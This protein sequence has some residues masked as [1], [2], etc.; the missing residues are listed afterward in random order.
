MSKFWSL[1]YKWIWN[2]VIQEW[3]LWFLDHDTNKERQ[4]FNSLMCLTSMIRRECSNI[5]GPPQV[6]GYSSGLCN[7][8]QY[9]HTASWKI[10]NTLLTCKLLIMFYSPSVFCSMPQL[11]SDRPHPWLACS[12]IRSGADQP[13][14]I[15]PAVWIISHYIWFKALLWWCCWGE[16]EAADSVGGKTTL[17]LWLSTPFCEF[18]DQIIPGIC[19]NT[20][21]LQTHDS[22][23]TVTHCFL[24]LVNPVSM[25]EWIYWGNHILQVMMQI[26]DSDSRDV[27]GEGYK[28]VERCGTT[29]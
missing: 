1:V 3:L 17:I 18:Q 10:L 27:F 14:V 29:H 22:C 4:I 5:H 19:H 28:H 15:S 26:W 6:D 11:Q 13:S 9:T 2:M 7:Y 12:V 25:L 23:L 24:I 8:C 21:P 16:K 20:C